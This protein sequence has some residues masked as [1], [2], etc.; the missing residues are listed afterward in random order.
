MAIAGAASRSAVPEHDASLVERESLTGTLMLLPCTAL[1][2]AKALLLGEQVALR[3]MAFIF[4][5]ISCCK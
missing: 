4:V 2:A 5:I 1:N 3:A